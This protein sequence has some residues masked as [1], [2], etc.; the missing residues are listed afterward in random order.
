MRQAHTSDVQQDAADKDELISPGQLRRMVED[1]QAAR[2]R[3]AEERALREEAHRR[4]LR[5]AFMSRELRPDA[6]RRLSKVV[7]QAAENGQREVL[8]LQ[9]P[10]DLC[11]DG[12]VAINNMRSDWPE[13]LQGF[14]RRGYQ[15]YEEELRPQGYMIRAQILSY[16]NQM[17]G[18]VGIFLSW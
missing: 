9:F 2:A 8:V 7:R 13:T 17:L 15:F 16:P 4:E 12:G 5:E 11:E 1:R 6:K 18:D 3:E 10:A 14:A